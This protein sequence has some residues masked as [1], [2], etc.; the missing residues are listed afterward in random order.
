MQVTHGRRFGQKVTEI[1]FP[2]FVAIL[3]HGL[4]GR[5]KLCVV[6]AKDAKLHRALSCQTVLFVTV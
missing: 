4:S 3:I 2:G 1:L 5:D 6:S